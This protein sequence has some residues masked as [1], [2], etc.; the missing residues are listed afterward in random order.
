VDAENRL[1]QICLDLPKT[2]EKQ[3]W[4]DPTFRV[5]DR[6]FAMV[7][8][9]DGRVSVWMKAPDGAQEVLTAAAPD[10][11]F[12]PPYVGHKGWIGMRLDDGPD[13]DE[14]ARHVARS[15]AL[16]APKRLAKLME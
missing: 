1:R 10:R 14:V 16:I 4:G 13:W 8:R 9:G 15:Y 3:A 11:F 12:R 6:I 7:K 5:R 2:I